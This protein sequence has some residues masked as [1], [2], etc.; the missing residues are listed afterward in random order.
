MLTRTA[1]ALLFG[2]VLNLLAIWLVYAEPIG[3]DYHFTNRQPHMAM[4]SAGWRFHSRLSSASG[5]PSQCPR[6]R[7]CGCAVALKVFGRTEPQL[8]RAANW[9]KFPRTYPAPGMVAARKGHVFLLL[10]PAN[11]N[12][13]YSYDP[14]SGGG[15]TREHIRS[16]KGFTIVNP[17]AGR[18]A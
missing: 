10:A 6:R 14:N 7:Y 15:L 17:H 2:T 9:L 16:I 3:S 13:W 5:P 1:L 4:G 11:G 18:N 12:N 8:W